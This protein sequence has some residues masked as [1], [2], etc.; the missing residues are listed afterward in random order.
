MTPSQASFQALKARIK[1]LCKRTAGRSPAQLID[2]LNPV[3]RGWAN[4]HR[5]VICSA[6][7][8]KLDD[9][10]WRRLY[11]WPK[12][13]HPN[14]TGRWIAGH[15]FSHQAGESWRFA[16]LVTGKRI[17]HVR[18]TVKPQSHVKVKG[19]ANPFDP[20]WAAC[21]QPRDSH[22]TLRASSAF[23]A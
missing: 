9:F 7:F 23:R 5:H 18:E 2:A 17:I 8:V 12:W 19:D 3:L 20:A 11:R 14:N 16:N 4:D 1:A 21:F 22:L 13:R 15:Y 6:T 10:V